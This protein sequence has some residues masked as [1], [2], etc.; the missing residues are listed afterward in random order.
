MIG[1]VPILRQRGGAIASP[2]YFNCLDFEAYERTELMKTI[3]ELKQ[4]FVDHLAA[5]DKFEMSM[6][7]LANYADLLHKAD[8]LFK[9]SYTDVLAS[10]FIPPFAATTWKKEEKKNG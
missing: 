8:A 4:E 6:V 5:M 3:D 10:G 1:P 9:P 7:E 2:L